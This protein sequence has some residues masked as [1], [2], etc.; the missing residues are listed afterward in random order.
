MNIRSLIVFICLVTLLGAIV[1]FINTEVDLE[2]PLEGSPIMKPVP[3]RP[4]AS[5]TPEEVQRV[6]LVIKALGRVVA[7]QS[8][9]T[10]EKDLPPVRFYYDL[11]AE[12]EKHNWV[13]F[14][15][16]VKYPYTD[17][18]IDRKNETSTWHQAYISLYQAE[19][20]TTLKLSYDFFEFLDIKLVKV[21]H[22]P[23]VE[24][25]SASEAEQLV[26][27]VSKR[28]ENIFY[29]QPKHGDQSIQYIFF[30]DAS[31]TDPKALYPSS[32]YYLAID[33]KKVE[34]QPIPPALHDHLPTRD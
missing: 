6:S 4:T 5:F 32:F 24:T 31:L 7:Q 13:F 33:N 23:P 29:Y 19:D 18:N 2:K 28:G 9:V 21:E 17:G 26:D 16:P 25:N 1:Y 22:T 20:S 3:K 27:N 30:A 34:G 14:K 11:K 15:L 10:D 12:R 8:R